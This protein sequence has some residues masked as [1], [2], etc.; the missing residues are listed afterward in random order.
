METVPSC[1]ISTLEKHTQMSQHTHQRR[2]ARPS[3]FRHQTHTHFLV[4]TPGPRE[5][6]KAGLLFDIS[7]PE[8]QSRDR[9]RCV[10]LVEGV[11]RKSLCVALPQPHVLPHRPPQT[12]S[13][14]QPKFLSSRT[15]KHHLPQ[16]PVV[17]HQQQQSSEVLGQTMHPRLGDT[18]P[19]WM[20][21]GHAV[22][23]LP[24][25]SC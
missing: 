10:G 21:P 11:L 1:T 20:C 16:T 14:A 6:G 19:T 13:A 9:N 4:P 22:Q 5:L 3:T 12:L 17:P 7:F 25:P 23:P 15:K 2:N 18:F 8:N 24:S